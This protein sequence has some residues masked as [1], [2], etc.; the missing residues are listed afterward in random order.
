MLQSEIV[1]AMQNRE[2]AIEHT[3]IGSNLIQLSYRNMINCYLI[4]DE[5]GLILLDTLI[6]NWATSLV[7]AIQAYGLPLTHIVVTHAHH[8]H[9][10]GLDALHKAWPAAEI[11]LTAREARLLVR[12]L[13]LD[14][15]EPQDPVRGAFPHCTTRP[16]R[17]LL[18]GDRV[19]P[20]TVIAT[21]GHTPGHAAYLDTRDRT[22]IAGDAF[23]TFGGV[24]VAGMVLPFLPQPARA[25]WSKSLALQSA[26]KLRDLAPSRLAVGHGPVLEY[27]LVLMD[28]A[29]TTLAQELEQSARQA[30][31]LT[32]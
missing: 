12:D 25:T 29:I 26:Y 16:T 6:H 27:P 1:N 22:L 11:A 32:P 4:R 24:G 20:L 7:Q 10:G 28:H 3:T 8:D 21:A 13:S 9:V 19:G 2:I 18:E 5:S 23:Q 30:T 14:A 15:D 31:V 17:F